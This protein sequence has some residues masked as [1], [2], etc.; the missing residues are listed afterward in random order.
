MRA[1]RDPV[2]YLD[3]P[4]GISPQTRRRMLDRVARSST[5]VRRAHLDPAIRSRSPSTNWRTACRCRSRRRRIYPTSP[6]RS[7][8]ST[9]PR[10][11]SPGTYAANC[12]LARRLAERDVR[13]IQLYHQ[14]WDQHDN[15][16]EDD[17][18]AGARDRPSLGRAG[19]RSQAARHA[20][21][22]ARGLGWRVRT[23]EL[24]ARHPDR[25]RTTAAITT[26]D[27]SPCGWPA[28]ACNRGSCTGEPTT[29]A[30]TS[31]RIRSTST[32]CRRR[33]CHQLG[34]DHERLTHPHQGRDFRLTDVHGKVVSDVIA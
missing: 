7:S 22:H 18:G 32:T 28:A 33:C 15:L 29:T 16:P 8:I 1:G 11:A 34:L 6:T 27:A 31:S 4:E 25:H 5:N 13:F 19:A 12:L 9:G 30:T 2:L 10:C 24:L 23:H 17:P 26:R 14:G 20:R 21:R 3:E